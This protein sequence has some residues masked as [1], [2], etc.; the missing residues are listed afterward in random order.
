M[1]ENE[2]VKIAMVNIVNIFIALVTGYFGLVIK[3]LQKDINNLADKIRD[4]RYDINELFKI[5]TC[6]KVETCRI[7]QEIKDMKKN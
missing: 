6:L 3:S 1:L 4:A 7:A 2:I 5:T